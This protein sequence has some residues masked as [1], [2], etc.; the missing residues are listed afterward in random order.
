LQQVPPG[1]RS[2][3]KD[4]AVLI[5]ETAFGS[6]RDWLS[7]ALQ[8]ENIEVR[9]YFCPPVHQQQLFRGL[10]DGQP[11]PMTE[12]ISNSVLNLPIYSSLRDEEVEKVCD[13]V[14]RAHEFAT[15]GGKAKAFGA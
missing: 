13:A 3:C 14:L 7:D 9:H 8:K 1:N 5:D 2:S 15:T 11:L 12:R 6:S 10:W 4:F